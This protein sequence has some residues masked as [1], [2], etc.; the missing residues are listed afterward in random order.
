MKK[1]MVR[2]MGG[3][4]SHY[5]CADPKVLVR[6]A[7]YEVIATREG[8]FQTTYALNGV[9]G[10]FDAKWFQDANPSFSG[11]HMAVTNEILGIGKSCTCQKVVR[12]NEKWELN[13]WITSPVEKIKR[14]CGN[15]WLVKAHQNVYVMQMQSS[16]EMNMMVVHEVPAVRKSCEGYKIVPTAAD[17]WE[18]VPWSTG[19]VQEIKFIGGNVYMVMAEGVVYVVQPG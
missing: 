8:V 3:E 12:N 19:S 17:G 10:W 14:V 7:V 4:E 1:K 16:P 6:G 5:P 2:Y 9:N 11:I 13:N 18:M 15:I